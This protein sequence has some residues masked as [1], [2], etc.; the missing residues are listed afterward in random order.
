M[1]FLITIFAPQ[2]AL[3]KEGVMAPRPAT[4]R[5]MERL[6]LTCRETAENSVEGLPLVYTTLRVKLSF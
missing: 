2:G 3:E 4:S 6:E 1:S 5:N